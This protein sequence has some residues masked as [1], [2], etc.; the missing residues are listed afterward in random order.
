MLCTITGRSSPSTVR[1]MAGLWL[2]C[3]DAD[4]GSAD[5]ALMGASVSAV[6]AVSAGSSTWMGPGIRNVL[7]TSRT[8]CRT[9]HADGSDTLASRFM[10]STRSSGAP[11]MTVGSSHPSNSHAGRF[12][13]FTDAPRLARAPSPP[14]AG[15]SSRRWCTRVWHSFTD[16]RRV[17]CGMRPLTVW[18]WAWD[19]RTGNLM[20]E[21]RA[22][23]L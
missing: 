21:N 12:R 20:P 14:V 15:A 1:I 22:P 3:A 18:L 10:R 17:R 2:L 23:S 19:T 9:A 16:V 7:T 6:S 8:A 5:S 11:S 4:G 13:I